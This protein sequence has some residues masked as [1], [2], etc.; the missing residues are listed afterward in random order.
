M[1]AAAGL[2]L[3]AG[4]A[5][6][7]RADVTLTLDSSDPTFVIPTQGTQTFEI[8]GTLS[9][10]APDTAITGLAVF[11]APLMGTPGGSFTLPT[12]NDPSI[13]FPLTATYNGPIVDITVS[14]TDPAGT[15]NFGWIAAFGNGGAQ[16][17]AHFSVT[18][19]NQ[20]A[21]VPEPSTA[22]V[23]ALGAVAFLAYGWS[24]H[25]RAQRR[26]AAA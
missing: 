12:A 16:P 21:T 1:L 18:L 8:D 7:A 14:A 17:N 15:Y 25:R 19:V 5:G 4:A 26:Q 24:R 20:A 10:S 3:V 11:Q 23:A 22:L 2:A 9:L 13:S 6:P